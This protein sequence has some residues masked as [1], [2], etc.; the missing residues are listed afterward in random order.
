LEN[1]TTAGKDFRIA[2]DLSHPVVIEPGVDYANPDSLDWRLVSTSQPNKATFHVNHSDV[3]DVRVGILKQADCPV[4]SQFV[5]NVDLPIVI[6]DSLDKYWAGESRTALPLGGLRV[7]VE[8]DTEQEAKTNL[9]RDLAAQFRLLLLL[10]SS[11]EGNMAPELL[12]NLEYLSSIM[13][14]K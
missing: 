4:D 7:P 10:N 14:P 11:R 9:A 2:D 1:N 8:G 12:K 5:L 6:I 3:T 13:S